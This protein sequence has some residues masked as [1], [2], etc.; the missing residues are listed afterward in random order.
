MQWCIYEQNY[1]NLLVFLQFWAKRLQDTNAM[2]VAVEINV[3]AQECGVNSDLPSIHP[4]RITTLE[5]CTYQDRFRKRPASCLTS[6]LTV[7]MFQY[8]LLT[9]LLCSSFLIVFSSLPFFIC[10][11]FSRGGKDE[12]IKNSREGT[13]VPKPYGLFIPLCML[14]FPIF[15]FTYRYYSFFFISTQYKTTG[16]HTFLS[17]RQQ[18]CSETCTQNY[19]AKWSSQINGYWVLPSHKPSHF[20][21]SWLAVKYE[22]PT[23][24][25]C[26]LAIGNKRTSSFTFLF[27]K[28]KC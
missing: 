7:S 19:L 18:R 1:I 3:N 15:I 24:G 5:P 12:C 6:N 25:F 20:G 23:Q 17:D 22:T 10:L 2:L 21:H 14:Y 13:V 4:K 8:F 28:L 9:S 16:T 26:M 11:L 27:T